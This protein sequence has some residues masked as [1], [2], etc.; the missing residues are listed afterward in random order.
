M[1]AQKD[2]SS[3][4]RSVQTLGEPAALISPLTEGL[5]TDDWSQLSYL[6]ISRTY[7]TEC[8]LQLI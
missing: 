7:T 3:L 4:K 2:S 1:A 8:A 6:D 5:F